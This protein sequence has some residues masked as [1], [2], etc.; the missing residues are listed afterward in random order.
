MS[1]QSALLLETHKAVLQIKDEVFSVDKTV[2]VLQV[3]VDDVVDRI[4]KVED[5]LDRAIEKSREYIHSLEVRLAELTGA[6]NKSDVNIYNTQSKD[7]QVNEGQNV[8]GT[9]S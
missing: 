6:A 9:N 4:T 5:Q 1:I 7:G 8:N 2:S 3:R